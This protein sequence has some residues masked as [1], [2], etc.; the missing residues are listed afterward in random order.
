MRVVRLQTSI[1]VFLITAPR[2]IMR[3]VISPTCY[4]LI[5]AAEAHLASSQ[6]KCPRDPLP[7]RLPPPTLTHTHTHTHP[8]GKV[9]PCTLDYDLQRALCS[10]SREH[11]P[12]WWSGW[13]GGVVQSPRVRPSAGGW[14][15]GSPEVSQTAG[16]VSDFVARSALQL[17][18]SSQRYYSISFPNT[19]LI[20]TFPVVI[21]T[22]RPVRWQH[23]VKSLI[24]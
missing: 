4:I 8:D 15:I 6:S 20:N 1:K 19:A 22:S 24:S 18:P 21:S 11:C 7:L 5:I 12:Q 9:G 14:V 16:G 10:L 2:V 17:W 23:L 13:L 3:H